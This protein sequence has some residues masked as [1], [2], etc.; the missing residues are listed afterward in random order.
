MTRDEQAEAMLR[1]LGRL[2][3]EPTEFAI[4]LIRAVGTDR[5]STIAD[6][7]SELVEAMESDDD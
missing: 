7:V 3:A 2:Y 5:A 6:H 1:E 4:L